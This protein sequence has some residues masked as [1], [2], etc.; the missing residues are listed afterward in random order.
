MEPTVN[1][2]D[3]NQWL[4]HRDWRG[5]YLGIFDLSGADLVP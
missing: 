3:I 1:A 5:N 4:Y 2:R